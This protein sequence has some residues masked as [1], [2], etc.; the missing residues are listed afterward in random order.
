MERGICI[1]GGGKTRF[2]CS[3]CSSS[4]AAISHLM[5]GSAFPDCKQRELYKFPAN[6]R[7]RQLIPAPGRDWKTRDEKPT[8]H[9]VNLGGDG[10][11]N[12]PPHSLSFSPCS[13]SKTC[14][15]ISLLL[16]KPF[17][18]GRKGLGSS[19]V[20]PAICKLHFIPASNHCSPCHH[21]PEC[22]LDL[23]LIS[24]ESKCIWT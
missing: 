15:C 20:R 19:K 14:L 24:T 4:S 12:A 17:L 8:D 13:I 2:H 9:P 11:L 10:K 23:T 7:L 1:Q 6:P 16:P 5:P 3:H 22:V 18:L 21:I